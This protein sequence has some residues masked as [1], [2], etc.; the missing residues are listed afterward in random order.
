MSSIASVWVQLY[1]EGENEPRHRQ[2]TSVK[3]PKD[4]EEREWTIDALKAV[5]LPEFGPALL[6]AVKVYAPGTERPFSEDKALNSWDKIPSESSGPQP[7]IVVAPASPPESRNGK[8]RCCFC[9]LVFKCC[10]EYGND[11]VLYSFLNS[12]V[13]S[14]NVRESRP[15]WLT[16]NLTSVF[17]FA[18]P[19]ILP[20]NA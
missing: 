10:F 19:S 2:P 17:L 18:S 11:S 3:K 9:I 16:I 1:Y 5:V 20:V 8:L 14:N 15:S 6:G 13:A 7:L 4:V 12:N